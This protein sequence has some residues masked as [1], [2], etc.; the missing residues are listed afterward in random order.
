ME[1]FSLSLKKEIFGYTNDNIQVDL[2]TLT[3][4]NGISISITNYG[5]IIKSIFTPDKNDKFENIVI[6]FNEFKD[7]LLPNPHFGGIIGRYAN[8]IKQGKLPIG[9]EVYNL[10]INE[11]KNHIHGGKVGFD[12]KIWKVKEN[13]DLKNAV[14][15]VLSYFSP[16]GEE[17]YPGNLDVVVSYT[18]N[19]ENELIIDYFAKSDKDTHVN[20]TNHSYFNLCPGKDVLNHVIM[21]DADKCVV[22]DEEL[23]PTGELKEV[24]GSHL[25]FT[26]PKSVCHVDNSFDGYDSCYCLNDTSMKSPAAKLYDPDSKRVLEVF[27][28]Q[29]GMQFYTGNKLNGTLVD[30][31]GKSIEKYS[32][33]C[34]ETQ[35]YSD[36]SNNLNFPTTILK[37]G[38]EYEYKSIFKFSRLN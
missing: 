21:I 33:L 22:Y 30:S 13:T 15:I 20:L 4:S 10:T 5:G 38:K 12:R 16:D 14:G 28:N 2:Y 34:L 36:S 29:P 26:I 11:G 23:I 1:N 18:L 3:N 25:D 24:K 8:R 6:G 19:E 9:N 35:H 32:G 7:Y 27:T 31:F 37:V 17:G